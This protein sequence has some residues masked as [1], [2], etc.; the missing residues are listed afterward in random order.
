MLYFNTKSNNKYIYRLDSKIDNIIK[1]FIYNYLL[2][3]IINI[4]EILFTEILFVSI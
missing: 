2:I 3:L 4:L 1:Q